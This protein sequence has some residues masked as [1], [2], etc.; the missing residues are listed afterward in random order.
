MA[1]K[2]IVP[3]VFILALSGFIA[4]KN[5]VPRGWYISGSNK[6]DYTI[7]IDKKAFLG[8]K[9]ATIKSSKKNSEGF[10]TLMQKVSAKNYAGKD[11]R[12]SCY[13]KSKNVSGWAS[14]W[15]RANESGNPSPVYFNNFHTR[16]YT[17]TMEWTELKETITV[18]VQ[19]D[20]IAFGVQLNGNG[21]IWA[22][23]FKIEL[24][25]KNNNY[26]QKCEPVNLDFED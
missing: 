21:Q 19:A 14:P 22:D 7:S 10:V 5:E 15:F 25:G 12:F 8:K 18:P 26:D 1:L 11:I 20:S 23:N 3:F 9:A 17:G 24:L 2:I 16:K 4:L 13:I 6:S